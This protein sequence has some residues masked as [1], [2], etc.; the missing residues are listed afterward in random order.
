MSKRITVHREITYPGCDTYREEITPETA[1]GHLAQLLA[2]G[3]TVRAESDVTTWRFELDGTTETGE[4][5]HAI[6]RMHATR[7]ALTDLAALR[8]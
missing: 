1:L 4:Q 6:Y 3:S 5:F 7:A 2:D 8:G